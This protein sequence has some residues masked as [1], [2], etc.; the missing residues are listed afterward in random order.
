MC[1]EGILQSMVHGCNCMHAMGSG[2]AGQLARRYPIVPAKDIDQS[3]YGDMSK[4][5][6]FSTAAVKS[7]T[8]PDVYFCVFNAYT[9]KNPAYNGEDV[10]EYDAFPDILEEIKDILRESGQATEE[11]P[12]TIGFPQIGAGLAGGDWPRIKQMIVDAFESN[13]NFIVTL[14]EYDPS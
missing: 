9:Q 7:I 10:F 8:N 11:N 1:E 3:E 14:V 6:T 12:Y 13:P 4:I 5:G 2:I